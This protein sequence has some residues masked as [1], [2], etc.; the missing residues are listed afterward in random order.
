MYD[1]KYKK[2]YKYKQLNRKKIGR[3][4]R[5]NRKYRWLKCKKH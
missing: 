2:E 5:C 4:K 3:I 1:Y